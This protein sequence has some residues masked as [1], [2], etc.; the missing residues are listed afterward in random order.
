MRIVGVDI[1]GTIIQLGLF[2]E[3]GEV[4]RVL[5]YE[6]KQARSGQY[7]M[8]Q[9]IEQI[10]VL[11]PID[12]IGVC[13]A[14]QV[15][16]DSGILIDAI[17]ISN[18]NR[19]PIKSI[20]QCHFQ[21]PVIVENDVNAAAIGEL[22]FGKKL[23][24]FLFVA[25]GTG[26]GAAIVRERTLFTGNDGFAGEVG[27]MVTHAGGR[28][29]NCGLTGCYEMYGSTRALV[30]EAKQLSSSYVNGKIIFNA[31]HEGN[32]QIKRIVSQWI[33]DLVVGLISL[34]HIFNPTTLVLGGSVMQQGMLADMI[35]Q[36]LNAQI[37][38]SFR[39]IPVFATSLGN[40][41]G[42]LGVVSLLT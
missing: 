3:T 23:D 31:Y 15:E 6:T 11:E 28:L 19:L 32:E 35:E 13:I 27:H 42:M 14:G 38:P 26:I 5:E 41:S 12:A 10:T 1:G 18:T 40:K 34:V 7:M 29:C 4:Y 22:H 30:H 8:K 9:L 20:L 16:R 37:I 2:D 33:N 17:N 21:V 39:P 25:Y 36:R 24:D